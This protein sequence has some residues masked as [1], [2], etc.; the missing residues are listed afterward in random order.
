MMMSGIAESVFQRDRG[1][2]NVL[3][4]AQKIH[5]EWP[6]HLQHRIRHAALTL[7][8]S[9]AER[10]RRLLVCQFPRTKTHAPRFSHAA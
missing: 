7:L 8:V 9:L 4:C 1:D 3:A 5:P 10:S 2:A 6:R